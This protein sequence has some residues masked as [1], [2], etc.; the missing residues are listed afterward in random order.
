MTDDNCDVT[1][2][3]RIAPA[4]APA[5]DRRCP[6]HSTDPRFGGHLLGSEPFWCEVCNEYA[7]TIMLAELHVSE[8]R[9]HTT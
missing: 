8:E 1:L 3:I 9:G 4:F 2:K 5:S 7:E 6:T